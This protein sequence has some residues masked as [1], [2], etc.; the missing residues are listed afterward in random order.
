MT[1]GH[2]GKSTDAAFF[3]N[4]AGH[5]QLFV[6][7]LFPDVKWRKW[8]G[9]DQEDLMILCREVRRLTCL[10]KFTALHVSSILVQNR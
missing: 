4:F 9:V 6:P 1:G 10:F 8:G 3:I 5:F 2:K 7:A